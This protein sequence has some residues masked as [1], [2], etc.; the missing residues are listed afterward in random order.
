MT[1]RPGRSRLRY[2]QPTTGFDSQGLLFLNGICEVTADYWQDGRG[3]V[4]DKPGNIGCGYNLMNDTCFFTIDG[5]I[6][7]IRY[8]HRHPRKGGV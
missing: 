6:K 2:Q 7:C 4:L 3:D 1:K 8:L 5:E